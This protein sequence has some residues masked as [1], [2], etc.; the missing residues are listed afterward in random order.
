[1]TAGRKICTTLALTFP[2]HCAIIRIAKIRRGLGVRTSS[3][4]FV[5]GRGFILSPV[6]T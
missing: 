4:F 1:M 5:A 2:F 3:P 6:R